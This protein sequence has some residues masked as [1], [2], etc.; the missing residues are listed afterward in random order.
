MQEKFGRLWLVAASCRLAGEPLFTHTMC[1]FLVVGWIFCLILFLRW[2]QLG[3]S[4]SL[5]SGCG[6]LWKFCQR[7]RLL[8]CRYSSVSCLI[9]LLI[10][11][12]GGTSSWKGTWWWELGYH[13][14]VCL[15]LGSLRES[16]SMLNI[17]W[18]VDSARERALSMVMSSVWSV[19]QSLEGLQAS[20]WLVKGMAAPECPL[21]VLRGFSV[22]F[23]F[24]ES[25]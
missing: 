5:F 9:W 24:C 8:L 19:E 16:E 12:Y 23:F 14:R 20:V 22:D 10:H 6:L 13:L 18:C 15:K 11:G 17:V 25:V 1:G 3:E 4:Y 21:L 7:L 2:L